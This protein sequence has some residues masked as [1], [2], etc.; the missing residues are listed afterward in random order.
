MGVMVN[1][2]GCP[3]D[4]DGDR[5]YDYLD[6]CPNT[7]MGASVDQNGCPLDSDGD[8]VADYLDKCPNTP[9]DLKVNADGC[10]VLL[11]EKVQIDLD[12]QFDTN[13]SDI[14]PQY[15]DQLKKVADFMETYPETKAT[16]EGH[17]DSRGAAAYNLK[18]SQRRA[19]SVRMYL[20][21]KFN[22]S[23]NRIN[24]IGYGEE[25]PIATNDTA[26]GRRLNR[27]IQAVLSA[28]KETYQKR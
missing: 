5:V 1:S 25:K 18:L 2:A 3:L 15:F 24:A 8:G 7:P 10:P 20:I 22:I 12:V 13:K 17:S 4:S 14:K 19:E 9:E 27:R 21:N 23:P 11:K 26:E 16:I 6:K 28:E